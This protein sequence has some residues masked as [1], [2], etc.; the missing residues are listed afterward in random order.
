MNS[1]WACSAL[2]NASNVADAEIYADLL[3]DLVIN[4]TL[5]HDHHINDNEKPRDTLNWA[6]ASGH[7][8]R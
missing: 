1:Q 8:W 3:S 7:F 4:E 5:Q 6:K 2:K